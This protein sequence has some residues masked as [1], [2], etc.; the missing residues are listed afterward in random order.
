VKGRTNRRA[1]RRSPPTA[2]QTIDQSLFDLVHKEVAAGRMRPDEVEERLTRAVRTVTPKLAKSLAARLRNGAPQHLKSLRRHQDRFERH[3]VDSWGPASDALE[4]LNSVFRDFAEQLF[5]EGLEQNRLRH[6][7]FR[8][9]ADLHARA[10]RL[11]GEIVCLLR[12]GFADGANA[13]WRTLHEVAV[14]STLLSTHDR[15]LALR[16]LHHYYV[17]ECKA[18]EDYQLHC[19]L[20]GGKPIP[21]RRLTAMRRRREKLCARFGK[22][23]GTDWG[24]AAAILPDTDRAPGFPRLEKA[25]DLAS[26]RPLVADAN[27]DVHGGPRGLQPT[28]VDLHGHGFLLAGASDAGLAEPGANAAISLTHIAW[29][30]LNFA[31]SIEHSL[32]VETI[33]LLQLDCITEFDKAHK[34]VREQTLRNLAKRARG[35]EGRRKQRGRQSA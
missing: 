11:T 32:I 24:W 29:A 20:L 10:C 13:R 27:D 17:K 26:F 33:R 15:N 21:L 31:P 22:H 1:R 18:A 34:K 7:T 19:H 2:V 28:G 35:Q 5:R 6:P 23:Y 30:R 16:Y 25:C 14:V 3:M 12:V 9:L 4:L 8:A